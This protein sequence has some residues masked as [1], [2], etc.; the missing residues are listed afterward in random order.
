MATDEATQLVWSL[1]AELAAAYRRNEAGDA[2]TVGV[3]N[4]T[5]DFP[6]VY[7]K[8]L[9]LASPDAIVTVSMLTEGRLAVVQDLS[10]QIDILVLA[11]TGDIAWSR[12]YSASTFGVT[13]AGGGL[14]GMGP[15]QLSSFREL[16]EG[17]LLTVVKT[18]QILSGFDFSPLTP[19]C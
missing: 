5:N 18:E 13:G 7:E 12:R 14:P 17:F 3:Y 10:S 15:Q 11:A 4:T 19:L 16:S 9:V 2:L 6:P 8:K 1:D